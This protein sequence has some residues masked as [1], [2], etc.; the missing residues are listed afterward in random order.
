MGDVWG[1]DRARDRHFL[2]FAFGR[3]DY[4]NSLVPGARYLWM[5][6]YAPTDGGYGVTVYDRRRE[7]MSV[8]P[9]PELGRELP[10]ACGRTGRCGGG[11]RLSVRGGRLYGDT[12]P[13]TL[14][15]SIVHRVEFPDTG[16]VC[17]ARN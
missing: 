3:F 13:L 11:P 14:P 1:Y 2:L 9:V 15:D 5:G 10:V 17:T 16:R 8:V 6:T 7:R 12:V 4:P